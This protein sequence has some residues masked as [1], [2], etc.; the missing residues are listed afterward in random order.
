MPT[1][2]TTIQFT[3]QGA[4]SIRQ[5]TQRASSFKELARQHG[6]NVTQVYWTLGNYD[7]LL[8]FDADAETAT[9]LMLKLGADGNVRTKTV[10]AFT[11][12]E[13]KTMTDTLK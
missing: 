3:D 5:T 13:I 2:I 10:Q 4:R 7:G 9:K 8:I 1:F 11:E 6:A 12:A